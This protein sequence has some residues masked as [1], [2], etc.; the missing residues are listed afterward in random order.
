EMAGE[1]TCLQS[2]VRIVHRGQRV[3]KLIERCNQCD[4]TEGLIATDRR[5][6]CHILEH[7]SFEHITLAMPTCEHLRSLFNGVMDPTLQAGCRL[8]CDHR[9]EKGLTI[10]RVSGL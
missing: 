9:T 8:L 6:R 2:I 3:I 5:V 1:N 10:F 7:G 4:G